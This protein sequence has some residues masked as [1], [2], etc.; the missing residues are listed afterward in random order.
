[1]ANDK[2]SSTSSL[3]KV[4]EKEDEAKVTGCVQYTKFKKY[5]L[6]SCIHWS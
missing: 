3:A 2:L 6:I 1:M 4:R 5:I